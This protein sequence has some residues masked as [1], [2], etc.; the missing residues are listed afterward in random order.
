M[1]EAEEE[2]L[3]AIGSNVAGPR[4][5]MN[6][7]AGPETLELL[8]DLVTK[9]FVE[10]TGYVLRLPGPVVRVCLTGKGWVRYNERRKG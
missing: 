4:F 7:D 2:L 1:T 3:K 8:N 9:G 10:S 6:L 5:M